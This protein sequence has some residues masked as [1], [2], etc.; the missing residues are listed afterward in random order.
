MLLAYPETP[1]NVGAVC[2]MNFRTMKPDKLW[3]SFVLTNALTRA[4]EFDT[5]KQITGC[6]G[7]SSKT[8]RQRL[9]DSCKE[10]Y[11]R[12]IIWEKKNN[13]DAGAVK[14][15]GHVQFNCKI[16]HSTL[17]ATLGAGKLKKERSSAY[18]QQ[19]TLC[20][21]TLVDDV[22]SSTYSD[23]IKMIIHHKNNDQFG[24]K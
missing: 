17:G 11:Q 4:L 12:S 7:T 8:R 19:A 20:R 6:Q 5:A 23:K 22:D 24:N 21:T 16:S 3:Y 9:K 1:Q 2:W 15:L 10:D 13:L 18:I 14:Y